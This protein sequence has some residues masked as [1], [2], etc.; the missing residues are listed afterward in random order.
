MYPRRISFL[1][2]LKVDARSEEFVIGEPF[3]RQCSP[4]ERISILGGDLGDM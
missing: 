2:E 1:E 4:E 3:S